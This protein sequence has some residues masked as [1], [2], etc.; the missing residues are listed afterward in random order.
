VWKCAVAALSAERYS[1]VG[2]STKHEAKLVVHLCVLKEVCGAPV[3]V[4]V[5]RYVR[6]D[7]S[8]SRVQRMISISQFNKPGSK[9]SQSVLRCGVLGTLLCRARSSRICTLASSLPQL[10]CQD[11]CDDLV[12]GA[13]R[14]MMD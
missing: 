5:C 7:G 11:H 13:V 9:V 4:C 8:V 3:C 12:S 14:R 6:L 2:A 1:A 10:Q